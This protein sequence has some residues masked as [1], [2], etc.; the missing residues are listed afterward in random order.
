M[1]LIESIDITQINDPIRLNTYCETH[2]TYFK[3]RKS[4]KKGIKNGEVR[5][6]DQI[7]HGGTWLKTG[8][9]ISILDLEYTP[10]KTYNLSLEIVFEDEYL[11]IINKPAGLTVS[12]NQFKTLA[13]ALS[14][15]LKP[16]LINDRLPWPLPVHRLDNQTSGLIIVAKTKLA[17]VILGQMFANKTIKKTYH[18]LIMG[19]IN[20]NGILAT[21]IEQK[22]ATTVYERIETVKS[23]KNENISMVRLFPK[24]GRTHQIRIHLATNGT[25]ILGDKLYSKST[26]KHK[27]LFLTASGLN[28]NHPISNLPIIIEVP[29]PNK[30]TTRLKKRTTSLG[31]TPALIYHFFC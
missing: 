2:V 31:I 5:L 9:I 30:F 21:Q 24:T 6:N 25:P 7:V 20:Q 1:K 12:G 26:L 15:N 16:S 18:A 17:R 8:D 4:V 3:S 27:G 23:L 10:P 14:Y 29:I 11:A 19:T 22:E 13:N 28:F